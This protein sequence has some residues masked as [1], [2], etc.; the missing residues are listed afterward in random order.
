MEGIQRLQQSQHIP[1]LDRRVFR[2][3]ISTASAG[4]RLCISDSQDQDLKRQRS[5][6]I[7]ASDGVEEAVREA[8]QA[9]P[10]VLYFEGGFIEISHPARVCCSTR[11]CEK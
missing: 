6:K 1:P 3:R 11:S 9:G 8:C 2:H 7:H 5:F 10:L 4:R